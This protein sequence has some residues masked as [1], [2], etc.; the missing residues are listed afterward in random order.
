MRSLGL[1]FAF[2]VAGSAAGC[3]SVNYGGLTFQCDPS[4][5]GGGACPD[6][7]QCDGSKKLCVATGGG[8]GTSDMAGGM[9]SQDMPGGTSTDM[10]G[11]PVSTNACPSGM[12]YD[13][14]TGSK[15]AYACQTTFSNTTG[16]TADAQ[17]K[18]GYRLCSSTTNIDLAACSR[19]GA[20]TGG[21]FISSLEVHRNTANEI[22]CGTPTTGHPLPMWAG[23]GR[24]LT[25]T[26][27]QCGGFSMALD[28]PQTGTFNCNNQTQTARIDDVT[29]SDAAGGV[30]CCAP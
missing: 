10:G 8:S 29:N 26:V 23:C 15:K 17:C 4:Q 20:S 25:T 3:Y 1:M 12:G 2:L 9:T 27:S 13:V 16:N 19:V 11:G 14:T 6:G 21:F 30:L 24:T 28:C 5:P 22:F 18:N 7:Y